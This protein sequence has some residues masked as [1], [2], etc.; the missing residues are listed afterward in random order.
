MTVR[1]YPD[2]NSAAQAAADEVVAIALSS[3]ANNGRFTLGVSGGSTAPILYRLLASEPHST[4]IDWPSTH[5][6]WGD[7][8]CVPPDD[9]E[10]NYRLVKTSL[11][12]HVP[13][14]EANIHRMRGELHP[15][16]AAQLYEKELREFFGEEPIFD[17]L[18]QGMGPDGHTASLFPQSDALQV[19]DR[20]VVDTRVEKLA[21]PWRLTLTIPVINRAANVLFLVAGEQKAETLSDVVCGP[22]QPEKYPSQMIQPKN[23]R[24]LWL[25]DEAAAAQLP[26][27]Q[28]VS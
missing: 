4:Q 5:V 9:R 7:E 20:W 8:R 26:G 12:D 24:L 11:L 14:P 21:T 28:S 19:S 22:Y 10:S 27:E 18:I 2:V 6:F 1:V 17:L 25:I 16:E 3:V 13:I 15:A 23:G